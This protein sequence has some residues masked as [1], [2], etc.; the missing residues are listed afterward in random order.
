[1]RQPI[2]QVYLPAPKTI[3]QPNDSFSD[4][5]T[6]NAIHEADLLYLPRDNGHKYVLAVVDVAT[7]YKIAVPLMNKTSKTVI[8]AFK[9]IY[10]DDPLKPPTQL[11][12]DKGKEFFKDVTTY[13]N[14]KGTNI[15]R[16]HELTHI[17]ERFNGTL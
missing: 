11:S 7:R 12:V 5:L 10:D 3:I 4:Y 14:L 17:V 16:S 15:Y 8:D 13:F 1:M 2:Y 6:I 9:F